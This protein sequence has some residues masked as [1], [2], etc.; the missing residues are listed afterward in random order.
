MP[1]R[2]TR[3]TLLRIW[4]MLNLLPGSAD[5]L[6][7]AEITQ[8]LE[9]RGFPISQRQVERDLAELEG[10]VPIMAGHDRPARWRWMP[11]S[12]PSSWSPSTSSG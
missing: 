2:S 7:A 4:E 11:G 3:D 9:D 6:T 10:A 8:R 12:A 1:T 5:G